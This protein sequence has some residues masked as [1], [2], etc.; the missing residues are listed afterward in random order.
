MEQDPTRP[1]VDDQWPADP[2]PTDQQQH[3]VL[4]WLAIE[5]ELPDRV[6]VLLLDALRAWQ[7]LR[8]PHVFPVEPKA[9]PDC[10]LQQLL[11]NIWW[12][13]GERAAQAPWQ[14]NVVLTEVVGRLGLALAAWHC[15][16][17]DI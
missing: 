2:P 1:S 16:D 4:A 13:L 5:A 6:A 7:P 14:D 3:A 15:P 10:D 8:G 11:Q 9:G 12:Q 17:V